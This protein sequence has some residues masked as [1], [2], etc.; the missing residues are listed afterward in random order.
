MM[1]KSLLVIL[2]ANVII[3]AHRD[4]YWNALVNQYKIGIPS[5]ILNDEVF[6]F[7]TET[8]AQ[9]IH[10]SPY[11]AR[12]Q[13]HEL[14][15]SFEDYQA[16]HKAVN[17]RFLASIDPG[18][19]EALA[20]LK[21]SQ[22]QQYAF[23]TGDALAIQA[24]AILGMSDRSVSLEKMLERCGRATKHLKHHFTEGSLQK[25]LAKGFQEKHLWLN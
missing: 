18:E 20:L 25:N 2:D 7:T 6:F 10:L 9:A 14:S 4:G 8:G 16:I 19:E 1:K 24:L 5:T 15:A 3:V 12:E 22:C 13:I 11:I 23:C 21:S 17:K